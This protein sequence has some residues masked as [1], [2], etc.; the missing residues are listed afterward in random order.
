VKPLV[1]CLLL[2]GCAMEIP[3]CRG[4]GEDALLKAAFDA[5]YGYDLEKPRELL[6]LAPRRAR[7]MGNDL[8]LTLSGAPPMVLHDDIEGCDTGA[9]HCDGYWLV[10]DLPSRHFYLMREYYRDSGDYFL[11]DDRTGHRTDIGF[12]PIFSPDGRRF[13]VV[14]DDHANTLEIWRRERDSAVPEWSHRAEEMAPP[15]SGYP[16]PYRTNLDWQGDSIAL[17]FSS[18]NPDRSWTGSLTRDA[19][20]WRLTAKRPR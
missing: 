10:A 1:F 18:E 14:D 16:G 3:N 17:A 15:A 9:R 11:V 5:P 13:L 20:G 19:H 6:A 4:S 8:I 2:A 12:V 7:R